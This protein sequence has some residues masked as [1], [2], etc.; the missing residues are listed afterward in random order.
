M[1]GEMLLINPRKRR[2]SSKRGAKAVRRVGAK[3]RVTRRKNP[4]AAVSAIKRRIRR[5]TAKRAVSR[6]RRRNPISMGSM[7]RG[8]V[9]MLKTA[10]LGGAGAVGIDLLMSKLNDSLPDSLKAGI[11]PGVNDAL[12]AGLTILLGRALSKSTKGLS[13]KM[14]A[15]AL[16]VQAANLVRFT[17]NKYQPGLLAGGGGIG[18]ANPA[19]VVRGNARLS[20]VIRNGTNGVGAFTRGSPLLSQYAGGGSPLLSTVGSAQMRESTVR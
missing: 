3:R 4:I 10:L 2:A 8:L 7:T 13:E 14:A 11:E 6:R 18:Y 9:P 15:G 19:R 5:H 16:A 17:L 1:A 20:P 12:K